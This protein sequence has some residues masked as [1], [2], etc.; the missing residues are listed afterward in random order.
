MIKYYV[1]KYGTI[2]LETNNED[3]ANALVEKLGGKI[4]TSSIDSIIKQEDLILLS[5][6]EIFNL[7]KTI[8]Y[9]I[10][11]DLNIVPINSLQEIL[12]KLTLIINKNE[13]V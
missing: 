10:D 11:N 9:V 3:E 7:E 8:K 13:W 5:K 6:K 1:Q 12:R 4:L 2:I